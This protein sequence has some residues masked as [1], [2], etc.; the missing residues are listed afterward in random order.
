MVSTGKKPAAGGKKPPA[1]DKTTSG[2]KAAD[3]KST[4]AGKPAAT[5]SAPAKKP[6]GDT[7]PTSGGKGPRKPIAPVKVSQ[8]RSWGPIALFV[9]VGVLAAGIIGYGAWAAFKGARSWEDRA[10][11]IAGIVNFRDH[12][13]KSIT[14]QE[15][16]WGAL[17]YAVSP[18]V[19]GKHNFNWQ[20]CMGD[21]YAAP[22]ANE[23]AV[24]SMEHGAVWITYRSDLPA[25]QVSALAEKVRGNEYMMMSPVD[26]LDSPISL[27]AWGYQLKVDKAD[28]SRV[29]EFIKALRQNANVE[30]GA[31]CGRGITATGTT[32]RDLGKDQPQQPMQ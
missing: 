28:D 8:G 19:G 10:A 11:D 32:P 18:P 5:K 27:Q 26:G 15:H 3:V 30:P 7:R 2:G 21:V 17:T 9:A 31:T 25:D 22:I 16:A 1:G 14:S 29:D 13:D 6:G 23:H 24:H 4:S 12:A 20:N